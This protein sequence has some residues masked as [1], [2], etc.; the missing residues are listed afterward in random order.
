MK[1][2]LICQHE[3]KAPEVYCKACREDVTAFSK[4]CAKQEP[5]IQRGPIGRKTK[6][7]VSHLT[8]LECIDQ[9]P[10][11]YCRLIARES[12]TGWRQKILTITEIAQ[13]AGLSWQ[14]TA[15]IARR[16]SFARVPIEDADKFRK[17]CG[18]TIQNEKQHKE[19]L[20]KNFD[21]ENSFELYF[22][23]SKA[24]WPHSWK[25]KFVNRILKRL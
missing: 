2:C 24:T 13:R 23:Y 9:I 12:K 10:P 8:Y 15:A 14:K 16:K 18:I 7:L 25:S 6:A 17:G 3:I 4:T 21:R 1:M 19:F 11:A 20:K 5:E 22:K